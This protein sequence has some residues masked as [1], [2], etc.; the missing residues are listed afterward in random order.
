MHTFSVST[1][2]LQNIKGLA[3]KLKKELAGQTMHT[4]C[5]EWMDRGKTI[6]HPTNSRG[7]IKTTF[8]SVFA[9]NLVFNLH[10]KKVSM[11]NNNNFEYEK[12]TVLV[13]NMPLKHMLV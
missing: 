7:G 3:Q 11:E 8:R 10:F 9:K 4:K 2:C 5:D 6:C 1:N 12:I 13:H